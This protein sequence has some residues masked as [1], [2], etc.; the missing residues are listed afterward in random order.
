MND[1]PPLLPLPHD[2][3]LTTD[4]ALPY[5]TE[6]RLPFAPPCPP[7]IS[8]GSA[9][10][11]FLHFAS[12]AEVAEPPS[13]VTSG[14]HSSSASSKKKVL[15]QRARREKEAEGGAGEEAD[16]GGRGEYIYRQTSSRTEQHRAYCLIIIGYHSSRAPQA[17]DDLTQAQNRIEHKSSS[18]SQTFLQKHVQ[19]RNH[20]RRKIVNRHR[21]VDEALLEGSP[22]RAGILQLLGDRPEQSIVG[23]VL[24]C[25]I[26]VVLLQGV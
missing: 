20:R 10:R 25:E 2:N 4:P 7:T 5:H 14:N 3:R 26:P 19:F 21:P 15:D 6:P 17:S 16:H 11:L 13:H 23:V 9:A 12:S 18:S 8:Q 24:K 1:S 22:G